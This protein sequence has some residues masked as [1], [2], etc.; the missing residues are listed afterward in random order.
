VHYCTGGYDAGRLFSKNADDVERQLLM[1]KRANR[2]G[3][4][5]VNGRGRDMA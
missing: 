1:Y 2:S 4:G 3:R 5:D